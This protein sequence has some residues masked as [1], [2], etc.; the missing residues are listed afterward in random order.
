MG[1]MDSPIP[2]RFAITQDIVDMLVDAIC[3][4]DADGVFQS[5]SA[6]GE[7]IFGY[8]PGEM[9]GRRMTD[10]IAPQDL[11][12]TL[13]QVKNIM[14]GEMMAGFENRYVRKDGSLVD[15]MWSARWA[16]DH[17]V[18]I[19]VARDVTAL[20]R[21]DAT[22]AAVFA[23]SEA[24]HVAENLLTMFERIHEI[25]EDLMPVPHFSVVLYDE[26]T[27]QLNFP[28]Q[29]DGAS[30]LHGVTG[31]AVTALCMQ[32]IEIGQP[33]LY[34]PG[35]RPCLPDEMLATLD[36]NDSWLGVPL[37]AKR[38]IIGLLALKGGSGRAPFTKEEQ[39]LL[40]FVSD[41]VATAIERK[42][43]QTR[44]EHAARYDELTDLPNRSLLADRLSTALARARRHEEHLAL[45][46]IDL[47]KFKPVN[48]Q[49]GHAAGDL[50]LQEMAHRLRGC[51][52]EIDTVARIGGDEFV[53]LLERTDLPQ[54][55]AAVAR[56]IRQALRET[57]VVEGHMLRMEASVG[58]ALYPMHGETSDALMK[59][60]DE[61]MYLAKRGNRLGVMVE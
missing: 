9:V 32:V 60:A 31:A 19:A 51:V 50:L 1:F 44:L 8:K 43:L 41:Q 18:R 2:P 47:D 21:A 6:G 27:G 55:A 14:A 3:V 23:I 58:I 40:H 33:V 56:K 37:K 61:Q 45:L 46:Y 59:Y 28:Y 25:I 11:A 53:V 15:I 17:K 7:A 29:S 20:R 36:E 13:D 54:D 34:S 39:D 52:R 22:R 12:R 24:A 48:D 10:F 30:Y 4:V 42:R 5:I 26:R 35:N 38:G 57:F 49:L 16:G